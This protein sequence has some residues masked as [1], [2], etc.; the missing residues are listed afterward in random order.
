LKGLPQL[1][2]QEKGAPAKQQSATAYIQR[3]TKFVTF[4]AENAFYHQDQRAQARIYHPTELDR[5]IGLIHRFFDLNTP[6]RVDR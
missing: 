3:Q 5:S 6:L 2:Q 4:Y 1:P